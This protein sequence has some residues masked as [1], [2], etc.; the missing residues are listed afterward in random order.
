VQVRYDEGVAIPIGPTPCAV[1]R[2]GGGE[3]SAGEHRPAIEPR[4][5]FI[6]DADVFAKTEG[7][8]A[9]SVRATI[10]RSGLVGD[11]GMWSVSQAASAG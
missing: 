10:R 5:D 9:G 2:K 6:P 7:N 8:T 3:A 4:E 1:A 11:P